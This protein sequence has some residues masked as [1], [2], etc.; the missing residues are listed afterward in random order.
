MTFTVNYVYIHFLIKRIKFS[1]N[2]LKSRGE[3]YEFIDEQDVHKTINAQVSRGYCAFTFV[4][5]FVLC[6]SS[7]VIVSPFAVVDLDEWKLI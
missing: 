7:I 1:G 6:I 5:I 3:K 2:T 4:S